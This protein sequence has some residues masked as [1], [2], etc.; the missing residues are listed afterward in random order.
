[1]FLQHI[2]STHGLS[3]ETRKRKI[4][5]LIIICMALFLFISAIGIHYLGSEPSQTMNDPSS[6]VT[7]TSKESE[8]NSMIPDENNT[9]L[10]PSG[11]NDSTDFTHENETQDNT[12]S[13]QNQTET[14]ENQQDSESIPPSS[15]DGSGSS[16]SGGSGSSGSSGSGN[17]D[18]NNDD[19]TNDD[20][21]NPLQDCHVLLPSY[22]VMTQISYNYTLAY[23]LTNITG[24]FDLS[25]IENGTYLGWCI[26]YDHNVNTSEKNVTLYSSYCPPD[27]YQIPMENWSAV[28]Y[29]INNKPE[30]A[31]YWD[32]QTAIWYYVNIGSTSTA[33]TDV[34]WD[35]IDNVTNNNGTSFI[36]GEGDVIAVIVEPMENPDQD[37]LVIIE[38]CMPGTSSISLE[39]TADVTSARIDDVVEYTYRVE[40]TGS[41]SLSE[42]TLIDDMLGSILLNTTTLEIGEWAVGSEQYNITESDIPGPLINNA[43]VT[44]VSSNGRN[45]SDNDTEQVN[46]DY[47]VNITVDKSAD[48][49]YAIVGDTITYSFNITNTGQIVL[50][51]ISIYDDVLGEIIPPTSSLQPG[52][53]MNANKSY[54]VVETDLPGP[55]INTVIV[56][57]HDPYGIFV[58]DSDSYSVILNYNAS[59][60]VTKTV[61]M[62]TA[63]VGESIRYQYVV[64]NTGN[65]MLYNLSL[66]DDKLG[67]VPLN[68]SVL[69]P[70][71]TISSGLSYLVICEDASDH[72]L[73]NTVNAS[74]VTSL[75]EMIY[76]QSNAQVEIIY[77]PGVSI[78][79]SV[80]DPYE[81]VWKKSLTVVEGSIMLFNITITNNGSEPLNDI[82]ISD[83][84]PD[85][86]VFSGQ[87]SI[88][89]TQNNPGYLEWIISNLMVNDS[90]TITYELMVMTP[91]TYENDALVTVDTCIGPIE[92]SDNVMIISMICPPEVWVKY[93]WQNQSTVDGYDSSLIYHYNAFNSIQQAVQIVCNCGTVYVLSGSYGEQL[94][95]NKDVMIKGENTLNT[96]IHPGISPQSVTIPERSSSFTPVVMAYGGIRSPSNII[97][98]NGTISFAIDGFTIIGGNP[99]ETTAIALRNVELGCI[100]NQVVNNSIN[101]FNSGIEL[102]HS[103][104]VL[105]DYNKIKNSNTAVIIDAGSDMIDVVHNWF[106]DNSIGVH[107]RNNSIEQPSSIDINYNYIDTQC[108][109]DIG[110]WNEI[111]DVIINAVDNWWG[112][113]DGP[114]SP[115]GQP[116]YDAVTGRIAES[117][118]GEIVIGLLRFDPWAGLGATAW[119]STMNTTVGT[120]IVFDASQS[121]GYTGE[122]G[123]EDWD[124]VNLNYLLHRIPLSIWDF[125][126]DF[127]DG[128]QGYQPTVTHIYSSPGE[129]TVMLRVRSG[130]TSLDRC[131]GHRPNE[132]GFV[133]GYAY[134]SIYVQ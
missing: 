5:I 45:V 24:I 4:I 133:Y 33:P 64:E 131:D 96:F 116:V 43:M 122:I 29:I 88:A 38:L 41:M 13:N 32:I 84:F 25:D 53:W 63:R 111:D 37:Q 79:K 40:N 95:I 75:D 51:N 36:P 94:F 132:D 31:S 86:L 50:D 77:E 1:M 49:T 57:G 127:G 93:N 134:Y 42:I 72:Y 54:E 120:R 80:Y 73:I 103:T 60:N 21:N 118:D 58:N 106:L 110:V 23:F 92:S 34:A 78:N 2:N 114:K 11:Q 61:N 119:I 100:E 123:P 56:T 12:A 108:S 68:T 117:V 16:G 85:Q 52:E 89:P 26:D 17:S 101:G 102:W 130:D 70:G 6:L 44:A 81:L 82:V 47:D 124:P 15:N 48:I 71:E 115:T 19:T 91:G 62:S 28:N 22:P 125:K 18:N 99:S 66:I 46:I 107:I 90:V 105:V 39:K 35:I 126:W 104:D 76:D 3:V 67:Q 97:S 20:T 30:N 10:Q 121:W 7:D 8:N 109:N 128:N 87:S 69:M 83:T 9:N 27:S 59:L 74:A 14:E 112:E 65:T 129:Y 98:G 55:I 113:A